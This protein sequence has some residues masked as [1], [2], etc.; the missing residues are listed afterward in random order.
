MENKILS[1]VVPA[2]NAEKFLKKGIPTFLDS[3]V[4]KD[5]EIIIVDDGAKDNTAKIAD[6][7]AIQNPECVTVIHKENGG[8][9]STINSGID[10]ARGEFFAV[11]DADDWVNTENFVRLIETIKKQ[12][13]IDMF[14][15]N[16]EIVDEKGIVFDHEKIIGV[17][18]N[19]ELKVNEY[20]QKIPRLYMHNYCI[21]TSLLRKNN[22]RCHEHHFYVDMEF[23]FYSFLHA[24]NFMFLQLDVYQY[25]V[26]REG[27]SVSIASRQKNIIQYL[28]VVEYLSAFYLENKVDMNQNVRKFYANNIAIFIGGYYSSL[29][30]FKPDKK[31]K[32]EILRFDAWLKKNVYEI[33]AAN[34]YFSIKML[35]YTNFHLYMFA[36]LL[37]RIAKKIK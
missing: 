35:R 17:P 26:G 13:H 29:L 18:A 36:S 5:I 23:V 1:I 33:Y 4:K 24:K 15:T 32:E 3:R 6:D 28:E 12:R 34:D 7:F 27:Q 25:L 37:Y 9:G 11:V 31:Y 16:C 8:H 19:Q 20:F 2:Y 22:V 30:S 21:R 14:L 10:H